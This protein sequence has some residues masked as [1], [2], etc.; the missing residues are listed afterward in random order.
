MTEPDGCCRCCCN[1][2]LTLGLATLFM[3]LSLRASKPTCSIQDFYAPVLNR[4]SNSTYNTTI[5]LHL[6]LANGNKD[7]GIYYD[8]LNITLYYG[9]NRS[10]P[11]GN[12]TVK[13]FYQGH[14]KKANRREGV[15]TNRFPWD[16]ATKKASNG[17]VFFRVDLQTA[18]RFKTIFWKTKR[19]K[20]MVSADL[21]VNAQGAKWKKKG[22]KL[23]SH[24]SERLRSYRSP[25]W[26]LVVTAALLLLHLA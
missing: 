2:I 23:E 26:L 14:K 3:W 20:M 25:P 8:A 1:T 9:Q 22:I 11:I 5:Y 19:K 10:L 17:T 21:A 12:V 15:Q 24:G 4:S 18:V 16:T 13:G 7:K 6:K